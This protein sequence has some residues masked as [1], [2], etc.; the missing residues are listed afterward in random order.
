MKDASEDVLAVAV[1]SMCVMLGAT[2]M[3]G[4]VFANVVVV[5]GDCIG[6]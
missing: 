1:L 2:Q 4:K 5:L 3:G 6:L